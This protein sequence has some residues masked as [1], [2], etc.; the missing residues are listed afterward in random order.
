MPNPLRAGRR[1]DRGRRRA[2]YPAG[3]PAAG[4]VGRIWGTFI[5]VI[6]LGIITNG[7]TL[8]NVDPYWQYAVKAGLIL[9]A[10]LIYQRQASKK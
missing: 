8:L 3:R 4:G 7:M 1:R 10:V 9:T 6:F 5:G 2:G